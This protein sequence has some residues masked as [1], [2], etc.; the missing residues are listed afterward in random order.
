MMISIFVRIFL[1]IRIIACGMNNVGDVMICFSSECKLLLI[2]QSSIV[3]LDGAGGNN[4]ENITIS[5]LSRNVIQKCY[6]RQQISK[7][8]RVQYFSILYLQ[9]HDGK[10]EKIRQILIFLYIFM[11]TPVRLQPLISHQGL[12]RGQNTE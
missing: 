8:S 2:V 6:T 1:L 5:F 11:G 10:L 4:K 12:E 3:Q 7:D 9:F